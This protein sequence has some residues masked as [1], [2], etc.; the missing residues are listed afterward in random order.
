M[1]TLAVPRLRDTSRKIGSSSGNE[2]P[3]ETSCRVPFTAIVTVFE[4][5][6]RVGCGARVAP[7][8][9]C[10]GCSVCS[11]FGAPSVGAL[12]AGVWPV[13]SSVTWGTKGSLLSNRSKVTSWPSDGTGAG[14]ES[15]SEGEPVGAAAGVA[16]D[17]APGVAGAGAAGAGGGVAAGS[18]AVVDDPPNMP[19]IFGAWR[20]STPTRTSP[21]TPAMIFWRLALALGSKGLA[22]SAPPGD[23]AQLLGR[24][25][26][27]RVRTPT[28]QGWKAL[29]RRRACSG[30]A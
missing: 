28:T 27:A 22:I 11:V 18:E 10:F 4:T 26:Q 5:G 21:S 9:A 23:A 6:C 20:N 25:H 19:R 12:G 17:G 29:V 1:P 2:P 15:T 24:E 8:L 30:A 13:G 16:A 14:S 7:P 3:G